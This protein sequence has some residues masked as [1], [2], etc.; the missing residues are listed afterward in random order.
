M[1]YTVHKLNLNGSLSH[2]Q[3][4]NNLDEL[5]TWLVDVYGKFA[6]IFVIQDQT[7]KTRTMTDNGTDWV[8]V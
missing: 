1:T 7:G 4:L 6:S 8:N 2:K 3:H 5:N